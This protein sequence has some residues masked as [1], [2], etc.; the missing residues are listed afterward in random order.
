MKS[1]KGGAGFREPTAEAPK[2]TI[3]EETSLQ[4]E[5]ILPAS[6]PAAGVISPSAQEDAVRGRLKR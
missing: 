4:A 3:I 1:T 5:A 6:Q 2:R